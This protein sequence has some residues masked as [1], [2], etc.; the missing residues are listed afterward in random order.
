MRQAVQVE[1]MGQTFSVTSEDG[2]DHVR[3]VAGYVDGKMR[4]VTAGGRVASSYAAA[5]LTALNIASEYQKLRE[6]SLEIEATID[7]LAARLES[8]PRRRGGD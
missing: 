4:E 5:V 6:R 2:E 1:I 7:R 8:K 3:R